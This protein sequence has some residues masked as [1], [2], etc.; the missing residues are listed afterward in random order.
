MSENL[1]HYR[2]A[3]LDERRSTHATLVGTI[4]EHVKNVSDVDELAFVPGQQHPVCSDSEEVLWLAL[5]QLMFVD[6]P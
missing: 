1:S 4:A 6:A 5:E 3:L 2:Q